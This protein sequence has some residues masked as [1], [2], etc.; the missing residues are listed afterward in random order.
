MFQC[1]SVNS[2][3]EKTNTVQKPAL[4]HC[5]FQSQ[6]EKCLPKSVSMCVCPVQKP[7]RVTSL[8]LVCRVKSDLILESLTLALYSVQEVTHEHHTIIHNLIWTNIKIT[9]LNEEPALS[10]ASFK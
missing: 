8:P 1:D 2:V 10:D 3:H 9:F 5:E 4:R 6:R 7:P